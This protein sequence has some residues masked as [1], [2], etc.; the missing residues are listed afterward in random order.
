MQQKPGFAAS[1]KKMNI[2]GINQES[3][4]GDKS[5]VRKIVTGKWKISSE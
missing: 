4:T 3:H 2:P 1:W 5:S